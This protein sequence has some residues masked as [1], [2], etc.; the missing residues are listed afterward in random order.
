M[1]IDKMTIQENCNLNFHLKKCSYCNEATLR[2]SNISSNWKN[3]GEITIFWSLKI[4]LVD[5][6]PFIRLKFIRLLR[7][8]EN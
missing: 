7:I 4:Q 2:C 6:L 3:F 5:T 1:S 8:A